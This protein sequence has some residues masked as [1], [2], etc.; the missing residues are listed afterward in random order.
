[1]VPVGVD[2]SSSAVAVSGAEAVAG[3][4]VFVSCGP[5]LS[6]LTVVVVEEVVPAGAGVDAAG[7]GKF[8]RSLSV[9]R[10]E[11]MVK[12][13]WWCVDGFWKVN[14]GMGWSGLPFPCL[15]PSHLNGF[16]NE[17]RPDHAIRM[18][19]CD[20]LFAQDVLA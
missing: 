12:E 11:D 4:A 14:G 10:E 13:G 18:S 7:S 5:V 16:C 20:W 3:M 6:L 8:V 2:V 1:M 17:I 9:E 15:L 19:S